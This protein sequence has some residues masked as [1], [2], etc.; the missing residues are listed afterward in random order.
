MSSRIAVASAVLVAAVGCGQPRLAGPQNRDAIIIVW[1]DASQTCQVRTFP[2][3][4]P[5]SRGNQDMV[6]WEI[7]DVDECTTS[8]D[9][10]IKF[11]KGDNDPLEVGCQR[12][13][14]KMIQCKV[15][16]DAE[17]LGDHTY[18]VWLGRERKEDPELQIEM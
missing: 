4:L 12:A 9:I 2:Y 17:P 11:D 18:S 10:E 16:R 14:R 15:K 13:G 7:F 8:T 1:K 5:A 6:R 3:R